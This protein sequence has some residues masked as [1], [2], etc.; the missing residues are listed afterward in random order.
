M[1]KIMVKPLTGGTAARKR[2][3]AESQ[4]RIS[5]LELGHVALRLCFEME[6]VLEAV[7]IIEVFFCSFKV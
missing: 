4:K 2:S 3:W 5:F 7:N 6:R 1:I